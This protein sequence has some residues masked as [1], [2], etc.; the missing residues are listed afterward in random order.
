[1]HQHLVISVVGHDQPGLLKELSGAILDSGCSIEDSRMILLGTEFAM[2]LLVSGSWS[3]VAKLEAMLPAL[4]QRLALAM[5][6]K[7]TESRS[8]NNKLMPYAV[9]VISL[10]QPNIV[11]ELAYFFSSHNIP[12]EEVSTRR[13]S[14]LH[15]GAPLFSVSIIIHLPADLSIAVLREQF[16]E[17]CDNLNLDAILEPIRGR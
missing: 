15:T 10:D 8:S 16:M 7:R 1:M 6:S 17:L 5:L 14:A 9:E 4:K 13:Y 3:A 11:H 2:L 12:I